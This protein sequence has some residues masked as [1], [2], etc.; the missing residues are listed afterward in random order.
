MMEIEDEEEI[1][2]LKD[3]ELVSLMTKSQELVIASHP[4]EGLFKLIES[5]VESF[6]E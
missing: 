5:L 3:D 6:Q 2:T 4:V 1:S